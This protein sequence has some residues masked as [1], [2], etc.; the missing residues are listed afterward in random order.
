VRRSDTSG[1]DGGT[2]R[3]ERRWRLTIHTEEGSSVGLALESS[4]LT[5]GRADGNHVQLVERDVSR[6]HARI[7]RIDE[8]LAVQDTRS[9]NGTFVNGRRVQSLTR[10]EHGDVLGIGTY[11]IRV[12]RLGP[13]AVECFE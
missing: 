8:A 1:G 13:S 2:D 6:W 10:L 7:L 4:V 11:F 12:T 5:I 9:A 3:G